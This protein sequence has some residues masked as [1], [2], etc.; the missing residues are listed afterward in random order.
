MN[1]YKTKK[2]NNKQKPEA[3]F[4]GPLFVPYVNQTYYNN[5][6]G[7]HTKGETKEKKQKKSP[8]IPP[9]HWTFQLMMA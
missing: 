9:A 6:Y 8:S 5:N 7:I 2:G 1:V 4:V 3:W